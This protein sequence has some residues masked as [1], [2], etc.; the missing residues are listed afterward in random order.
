MHTFCEG[1]VY[2]LSSFT[3]DFLFKCLYQILE[4]KTESQDTTQ[5]SMPSK[6]VEA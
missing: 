1:L 5:M 3:R 6:E 2:N 4:F